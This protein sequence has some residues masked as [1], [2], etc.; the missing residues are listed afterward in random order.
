M[1]LVQKGIRSKSF[2]AL[3]L[4]AVSSVPLYAPVALSVVLIAGLAMAQGGGPPPDNIVDGELYPD[5][6]TPAKIVDGKYPRQY[7]PNTERVG[8]KEMRVVALGT[9]MPNVI[10]KRQKASGWYVELGNGDKFLFDLGTGTMENLAALRPDW[11][12]VDKVFI[13]HLHSDHAGDFAPLYI[14]GWMNGRYTPLHVYG[15]SGAEPRLGTKAYVENQVKSWAWDVEGRRT[16]FPIGGRKGRCSR[17]RLQ[18]GRC[19]LREERR[20]DYLLSDHSH[21][22]WP[23]RVP[24]GLER[25]QLRLR[26]RLLSQ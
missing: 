3:I 26:W 12:K 17:V 11:S 6:F 10:T 7:Y 15:P 25:A 16:G 9:G 24:P 13:S 20:E 18:E 2:A 22:R 21:P 8:P 19:Y 23:R 1:S 5:G 4:A 14:G